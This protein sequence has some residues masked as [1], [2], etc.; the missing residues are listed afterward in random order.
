MFWPEEKNEG[1]GM[2]G[3]ER[4]NGMEMVQMKLLKVRPTTDAQRQ[5]SHGGTNHQ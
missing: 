1:S 3:Y 4:A 2:T 5:L